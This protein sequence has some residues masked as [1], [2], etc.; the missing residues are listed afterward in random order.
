MNN[1]ENK[2]FNID[3]D[4]DE[5]SREWRKN[6]KLLKNCM[7]SYIKTKQNCCHVCDIGKKCRKKRIIDSDYCEWHYN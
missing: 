3:I 6:K 4:F 5:A 2:E 7:F 1:V